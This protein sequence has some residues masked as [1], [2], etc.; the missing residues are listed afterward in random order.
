M[1][2]PLDGP[3]D[4]ALPA[5]L[6]VAPGDLVEVPFGPRQVIGVVWDARAAEPRPRRRGSNR[7]GGASTRRRCRPPLRRLIEHVAAIT[8]APARQR[9]QARAE[10][11]GRARAAGAEARPGAAADDAGAA[12]AISAAAPPGP[13]RARRSPC[14]ARPAEIARAA[15]VGAGVVQA[16]ARAGLLPRRRCRSSTST[17]PTPE[18]CAGRAVAGAG[19]RPRGRSATPD[20]AATASPCS[21]ACRAPARPRSI[22]RRSRRR[23][24]RGRQVLILLPE[25]ALTA[26]L[27]E[28]FERHFGRPPARLAFRARRGGAPAHLAADRRRPRAVVIGARSALFLPFPELGLI[29]VDEEHDTSFKQEDGVALSR[30]RHGGRAR[31]FRALPGDPGVGDAGARDRLVDGPAGSATAARRGA[32]RALLL[33]APPRRRR[34]ARGRPD[35]P[36]ARPA[37]ARRLAG[38]RPAR[39]ARSDPGGRRAVA[40]VPQPARLRAAHP[41]PRLR[42]PAALPELQRLAGHPPPAPPAALPPLRLRPGR[43]RALPELRHDRCAG[44]L[45]PGRRAP[46]RR[47]AGAAAGRGSRS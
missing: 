11:A 17:P 9:A 8:L 2:L 12:G 42:P 16:M 38:A 44:R 24:P 27:L 40:A 13:G 21:K 43:A 23:S 37:A 22:S 15:G 7:S 32:G 10:R 29:V 19:A 45:R 6:R 26:Q 28:R 31:P 36:E 47:G 1:P 35:R 3:F 4:Y 5:E 39:G 25:I 33:P 46:G 18:P 41:V 14:R 20:A 30:P 34:D